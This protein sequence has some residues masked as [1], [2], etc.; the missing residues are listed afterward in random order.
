MS[1][2]R[3][4]HQYCGLARGL[5]VIGGRWTLLIVRDMLL[6]P[7]RYSDLLSGLPGI[8]TNML[9][10]RLKEM[11]AHGLIERAKLP[12]P[13]SA[14]VYRLTTQG[15]ALEPI[16]MAIGA[17]GSHMLALGPRDNDTVNIGWGLVS[18]KRR[19]VSPH[20]ATVQLDIDGRIFR[21][22]ASPQYVDIQEGSLAPT[23]VTI[24]GALRPFQCL[25]FM[26]AS[27]DELESQ[28]ALHVEGDQEVWTQW[29]LAFGLKQ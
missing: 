21:V 20:R 19:Y 14:R 2:K 16:V 7:R 24:Q 6:G 29:L 4:Y 22:E 5:D 9:A 28:G 1:N 8:T 10:A 13:S 12:P 25:F 3:T 26:G 17:W 15:R 23:P 27:A 18:M 11:E